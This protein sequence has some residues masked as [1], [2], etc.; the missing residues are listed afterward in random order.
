ML[1][2]DGAHYMQAK[3]LGREMRKPG[4]KCPVFSRTATRRDYSPVDA[5]S[6]VQA[7]PL[8][9]DPGSWLSGAIMRS[10]GVSRS[11]FDPAIRLCRSRGVLKSGRKKSFGGA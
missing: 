4:R 8:F 6:P 9:P 3:S 7:V 1:A 11:G 2:P 10:D 5:R